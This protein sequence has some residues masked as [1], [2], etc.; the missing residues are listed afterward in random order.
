MSEDLLQQI[1]TLQFSDK[2][3]AEV[4]LKSFIHE[5]F[6]LDIVSV[7]LR[8]LAVSL[9]SFNGFIQLATG[10][11]LFFKTHTE[12]DNVIGEYYHAT[13][14][15]E[16]GYPVIQPVYSST[17][18][19]KQLLIYE[20]IDDPSVF[21]AA[22]AIECGTETQLES[23][24]RAQH[25][26]DKHLFE[27]YMASLHQQPA[28]EAAEAAV[29]QLFYHRLTGG[30]LARFYDNT[31]IHL[32]AGVFPM[33][34]IRRAQWQINGQ[35]YAMTLD[36]LIAQAI[37][38]LH[39]A[40]SGPAIIGHG[41][42]HNGNVFFNAEAAKLTYFD[43]AFAGKHH[44]LLDLTKPLFHN[45]FAMW[46]YFPAEKKA[47]TSIE[48]VQLADNHWSVTYDYPLHPV[49]E[50]FLDSK[51]RH[52]LIPIL[53]HLKAAGIL[54]ADWRTFLKAALFC[55]PFLTMNL[56]DS[57]KFPPEISLLGLVMAVEMGA[58]SAGTLSRIDRLLNE[59]E[60]QLG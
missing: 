4:L 12:P 42:A 27:L 6:D 51:V 47:Q 26:A 44:P 29:H 43:P 58:E 21:D 3:Q 48:M 23:L 5:M 35:H 37:D 38:L 20:V 31:D 15:S 52:T 10:R 17:E 14:L 16:V 57:A 41:D 8:P 53:A 9:N 19:S 28:E 40:Q 11:R 39:P 34:E 49:R 36:D 18:A 33:A 13:L 1:Q 46:M 7:E 45:I 24:T 56:A 54:R 50:M 60:Q 59:I 2:H 22:W 32:P 25:E 55:C 30:R